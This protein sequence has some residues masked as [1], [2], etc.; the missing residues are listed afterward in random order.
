MT[1]IEFGPIGFLACYLGT[2][3]L[4]FLYLYI[5]VYGKKWKKSRKDKKKV[6]S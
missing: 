2:I 4:I 1:N 3:A 6:G 5:K